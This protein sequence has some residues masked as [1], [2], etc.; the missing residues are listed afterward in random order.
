MSSKKHL[1]IVFVTDKFPWPLD[2]GGQIRTYQILKS[3]SAHFRV[4]LVALSPPFPNCEEPIRNLGVEIVNFSRNRPSWTMLF[5]IVSALF[6][7]RPYP[8]PKNFSPEILGEIRRRMHVGDVHALHL[9]HLDAAQYIEWLDG[10]SS[11]VKIVFD[12]HNLL[13]SFYAQLVRSERNVL[14]RGYSWIQW[15]KMRSYEQT[16]MRKTDCVVVCSEPE[17]QMLRDWGV[18]TG[19][20]VPNGVDTQFFTPTPSRLR[21]DGQPLHMV[22]TG[23]MDYLP[24]ADG[25]RWFLRS[26]LPKLDDVAIAYKLTVVGKNPPADLRAWETPGKIEFTGRVEDVRPYTRYA[27]VFVV[28]LQ[29]GGGTRLKILESLA[30]QVPVVST[31]LGAAGLDLKDGIHL[32]LAD[33]A[34][35]MVHAITELCALPDRAQEMARRGRQKVL[36]SYDWAA[37]TLPLCQYYDKALSEN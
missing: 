20:V 6:T 15:R 8:L 31:R 28:P 27:D 33:D 23:A 10:A 21:L 25:I 37:V 13:T 11:Q 16:I 7:R 5:Y 3:L 2:D 14:R 9:N 30:M 32:R 35:T 19:F 17:R 26:V 4:I 22:F 18:K 1:S 29:V 12:T 36:E 24:N 34:A